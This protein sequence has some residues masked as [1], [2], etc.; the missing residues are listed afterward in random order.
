MSDVQK[1]R[2]KNVEEAAEVMKAYILENML[3]SYPDSAK[4]DGEAIWAEAREG[5]VLR[6]PKQA[7]ILRDGRRDLRYAL[8]V[9]YLLTLA[10]Y[11][12]QDW[13]GSKAG[14]NAEI[15]AGSYR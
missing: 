3:E 12:R 11:I 5:G 10:A 7:D 4:D 9:I 8:Q 1:G 13:K 14:N 6:M 2:W 15:W